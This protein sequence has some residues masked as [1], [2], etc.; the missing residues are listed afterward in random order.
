MPKHITKLPHL[1][2]LERVRSVVGGAIVSTAVLFGTVAI[3]PSEMPVQAQG[4]VLDV[5]I[6]VDRSEKGPAKTVPEFIRV[7]QG[8]NAIH[9]GA[10][11]TAKEGASIYPI[12]PGKV[13][14]ISVSKFDYGRAVIV[15]HGEG[16]ISLYAH[17]GK[18]KV[19]EGQ[20]VTDK[21]VLGEVGLTG[22]TT[23][24]HLHLEIRKNGSNLNPLAFLKK[25]ND[26]LASLGQKDS[27]K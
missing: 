1:L 19:D 11:I 9:P 27:Y 3:L 24:Y 23:G 14:K 25:S 15:D 5:P 12:M 20:E 8:F 13:L 6:M 21:T 18:I 10:D 16:L 4:E 17:M 7:S 2:M 22:H 26:K